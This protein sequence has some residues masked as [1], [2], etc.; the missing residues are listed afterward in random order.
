M[1]TSATAVRALTAVYYGV[2]R[3]LTMQDVKATTL[4]RTPAAL[5]IVAISPLDSA[6]LTSFRAVMGL[7]MNRRP[8]GQFEQLPA[9]LRRCR[10]PK[11][12]SI[13]T[14]QRPTSQRVSHAKLPHK[15][16]RK[17]R[18]GSHGNLFPVSGL[19]TV[20][21]RGSSS[22]CGNKGRYSRHHPI[23]DGTMA[24]FAW[25]KRLTEEQGGRGNR[26]REW[27]RGSRRSGRTGRGDM[28]VTHGVPRGGL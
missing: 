24:D 7:Q 3:R 9:L 22:H 20:E 12:V 25:L 17:G 27:R 4:R 26:V 14:T 13:L 18:K 16:P 10:R 23:A 1:R 2:V 5:H 19:F 8:T 11:M 21:S 28:G 6:V 15:D